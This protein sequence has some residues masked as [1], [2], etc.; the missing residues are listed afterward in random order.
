[1]NA[2]LMNSFNPTNMPNHWRKPLLFL[3]ISIAFIGWS[4][5]SSYYSMY[6]TWARSDTF[7][8]GFF[9]VP[10]VLYLIWQKRGELAQLVPRPQFWILTLMPPLI[11][12]SLL[13][14]FSEVVV[15]QQFVAVIVLWIAIAALLGLTVTWSI[16]FPL[17]YLLFAVPFGEF[18][19]PIMQQFTAEFTVSAV[20][21]TGVPVYFEGL[22]LS[23]PAGD[24]E[25]AEACSGVRYLIAS[26]ALGTLYAY[27]SY[28]SMVKRVLFIFLSILVPVLANGVR[29]FAIVMIATWSDLKIATGVD[30]IIYGWIFFGVVMFILFWMGSFWIDIGDSEKKDS[31]PEG[32]GNVATSKLWLITL[33]LMLMSSPVLW[34]PEPN[35][36]AQVNLPPP[37]VWHVNGWD[38]IQSPANEIGIHFPGAKQLHS[39]A[40]SQDAVTVYWTVAQFTQQTQGQE[41]ISQIN[42]WYDRKQW[43]LIEERS[44]EV[45]VN[46]QSYTIQEKLLVSGVKK[47]VVWHWYRIGNRV[48]NSDLLGKYYQAV[49]R[50]SKK[51]VI[52]E[53]WIVSQPVS[54]FSE[55]RAKVAEITQAVL[56]QQISE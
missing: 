35:S 54:E 2:Q 46:S 26:L 52:S 55:S 8:H 49:S 44:L 4:L 24:F 14:K 39:G 37:K 43:R 20:R 27:L 19:I 12:L 23:T 29:A 9:I 11:L 56:A 45:S 3:F 48:T 33:A 41:L 36:L 7:A 13:A 53:A 31:I 16:A 18:L 51:G 1:M 25:V 42:Q 28:Q 32:E 17:F 6:Q 21:A 38:P 47:I 34:W 15:I 22:F 5:A 50:L 30:H 10:I 40:M